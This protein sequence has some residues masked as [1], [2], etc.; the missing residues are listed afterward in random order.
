M[1]SN[2]LE[3]HFNNSG[4]MWAFYGGYKFEQNP[5]Y[6]V[7]LRC[8]ANMTP[9]AVSLDAS[10]GFQTSYHFD[11]VDDLPLLTDNAGDRYQPVRPKWLRDKVVAQYPDAD[12]G[13]ITFRAEYV[14]IC[15]S[16]YI[17]QHQLSSYVSFY[18]SCLVVSC[19]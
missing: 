9:S 14:C 2:M 17:L 16:K 3:P 7:E 4:V 1:T 5:D 10:W 19:S 12:G 15:P 11:L 8:S 18:V 13:R 6:Q